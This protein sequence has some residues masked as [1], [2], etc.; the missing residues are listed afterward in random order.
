MLTR[1][2]KLCA[3]KDRIASR[4]LANAADH[5]SISKALLTHA[6]SPTSY[7]SHPST[8]PN[9]RMGLTI[10][11]K[12]FDISGS[13]LSDESKGWEANA[14]EDLKRER[15]NLVSMKEMLD[16]W[17][18]V[19]GN[20]IPALEKRIISNDSK[21]ESLRNAPVPKPNDIVKLEESIIKDRDTIDTLKVRHI[22]IKQ[23]VLEEFDYFFALK[24]SVPRLWNDYALERTKFA[25]LLGD[26]WKSLER[27]VR[28]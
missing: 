18:K 19:G 17:E 1:N 12:Y 15:D 23:S 11:A 10:T 4:Q 6:Q 26:N 3:L 14:L 28:G 5:E 8:A 9:I 7:P 24:I 16:R 25:E 27:E 20:N 2:R 22:F 13:I 21:L